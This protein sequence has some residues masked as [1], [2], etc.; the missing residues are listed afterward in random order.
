M[1]VNVK[2]HA[3]ACLSSKQIQGLQITAC[4]GSHTP[5]HQSTD[6]YTALSSKPTSRLQM[7]VDGASYRSAYLDDQI[8]RVRRHAL[9]VAAQ[10]VL[11]GAQ[12]HRK[13]HAVPQVNDVK[14]RRQVMETVLSPPHHPQKQVHLPRMTLLDYSE[15]GKHDSI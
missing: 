11:T 5:Q 15:A 1:Q 7:H 13:G 3:A 8:R 6:G 4:G 10:R 14:Q 2:E 9:H 12:P